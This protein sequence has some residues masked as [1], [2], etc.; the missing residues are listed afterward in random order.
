MERLQRLS[1]FIKWHQ[2]HI[3]NV[4]IFKTLKDPWGA[5]V[6]PGESYYPI[7][8]PWTMVRQGGGKINTKLVSLC[9]PQQ[10]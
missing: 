5:R 8:A 2:N 9:D 10:Y 3:L 6:S 7:G 4:F 1:L